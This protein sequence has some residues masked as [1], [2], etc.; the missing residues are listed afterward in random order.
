MDG[1]AISLLTDVYIH[2]IWKTQKLL[3]L[4]RRYS[5]SSY[6]SFSRFSSCATSL[7]RMKVGTSSLP[8]KQSGQV[9]SFPS[10]FM[11]SFMQI[12]HLFIFGWWCFVVGYRV[13]TTWFCWACLRLFL[14]VALPPS[15]FHGQTICSQSNIKRWLP[16]VW[17]FYRCSSSFRRCEQFSSI[18]ASK[19]NLSNH[20]TST[21]CA[22]TLKYFW[23]KHPNS[24]LLAS[25]LYEF[26]AQFTCFWHPI[27]MSLPNS[28]HAHF[29]W[30]SY[31]SPIY[32]ENH[33]VS[34]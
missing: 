11:E 32:F 3:I 31:A 8:M 16:A 30:L 34:L 5:S 2:Y 29:F 7:L 17:Y 22:Y 18:F 33:F 25:N 15:C 23:D 26:D 9:T 10:R 20:W 1:V 6:W 28:L 27:S 4:I 12:S 19:S 14:L 13:D 24:L 21:C